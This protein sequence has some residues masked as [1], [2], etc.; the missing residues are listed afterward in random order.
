MECRTSRVK[1]IGLLALT[2]IL[3]GVSWFC[4]TLPGWKSQAV[5]WS[6]LAFFGLGFV[7][8]PIQFFRSG[9][10]VTIDDRG[11]EDHRLGVGLIPWED[12]R[13]ARVVSV[14]GTKFLCIEA[15]DPTVYLSRMPAWKRSLVGTNLALGFSELTISFVGLSPGI[16][17]A[18]RFIQV[19]WGNDAG[20]AST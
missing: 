13:G 20:L 9:P 16:D 2:A 17:E 7:A 19:E 10:Q 18:W 14:K 15:D 12:I 8:I 11:I 5:G 3:V 4:T 1:M 6:G